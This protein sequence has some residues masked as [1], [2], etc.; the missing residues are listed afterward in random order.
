M[1]VWHAAAPCPP[2]GETECRQGLMLERWSSCITFLWVFKKRDTLFQ[3]SFETVKWETCLVCVMWNSILECSCAHR[4]W[5]SRAVPQFLPAY[6]FETE[7]LTEPKLTLRDWSVSSREALVMPFTLCKP[8]L[9]LQVC[10]TVLGIF[11]PLLAVQAQAPVFIE[12]TISPNLVVK[13]GWISMGFN[14]VLIEDP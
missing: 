11:M 10:P 14:S 5:R 12:W 4:G 8:V 9:G 6:S 1:S 13:V 2:K 7:F 3:T